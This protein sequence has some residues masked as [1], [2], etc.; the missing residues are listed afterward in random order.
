MTELTPTTR[1]PCRWTWTTSVRSFL[2]A[3]KNASR[4]VEPL[5]RFSITPLGA[6]SYSTNRLAK[7]FTAYLIESA[8]ADQAL[9]ANESSALVGYYADKSELADPHWQGSGLARLGL[10]QGQKVDPR[11]LEL[12]LSGRHHLTGERIIT[13]QG[14]HGRRHL[15]VGQPTLILPDEPEREWFNHHDAA[16]KCGLT[17]AELVAAAADSGIEARL[18]ED[19]PHFSSSDLSNLMEA[20]AVTEISV[21][22]LRTLNKPMS[23]TEVIAL[24]GFSDNYLRRLCRS[25]ASDG[26]NLNATRVMKG[27]KPEWVIDPSDLADFMAKRQ[28]PSTRACFDVTFTMEKSVSLLGLL[29]TPDVRESVLEAVLAANSTGVDHLNLNASNARKRGSMIHTQGLSVAS[30]VHTTSRADDPFLHVHN[31]VLNSVR[32]ADDQ[33]RAVNAQAL[34][35]QSAVASH[36]ATAQLRHELT[37]RFGVRWVPQPGSNV[38]EIDGVTPA[39]IAAFSKRRAEIESA[40]RELQLLDTAKQ[41]DAAEK[42]SVAT[43]GEKTHQD[44]HV[45]RKRWEQEAE[46][47]GL[48]PE[49]LASLCQQAQTPEPLTSTERAELFE[50]LA[51]PEGATQTSSVFVEA[52]VAAAVLRWVP[53]GQRHAHVMPAS[54]MSDLITDFFDLNEVIPLADPTNAAPTFTT[55]RCV[56]TQAMIERLWD[57]GIG[58]RFPIDPQIVADV[59]NERASLTAEQRNLVQ[60]W[61]GSCDAAQSAVG[62]PGTGKTFTCAA[63]VEVFQRAGYAVY[64]AAIKGEAA[65]LL[66]TEANVSSETVAMRLNQIR[67]GSLK[68]N[69][70]TLVLVDESSTI[71]DDELCELLTA[72]NN[73]GATLRCIGDPAQHS[74]VPAGGMW[75]HLTTRYAAHTPELTTTRRMVNTS[76]IEAAEHARRGEISE[77]LQ[78]LDAA[79]QL[80]VY[81]TDSELHA[82]LLARWRDLRTDNKAAP[83]VV[84]DNHTRAVLNATC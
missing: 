67:N 76:D 29:S 15:R 53:E 64:G 59:L 23:I 34:Y 24:T 10:K 80:T 71:S 36:L 55:R 27:R 48:T 17:E 44:P 70:K 46:T 21:K 73:A 1:Q 37:T 38:F 75:E 72:V 9:I 35:R 6:P 33:D 31:I 8:A 18:F 43:R 74:S 26:P 60:M 79:G 62:R 11:D 51:G 25:N 7:E 13:A 54:E 50:Y 30:F 83:L 16:A 63:A 68:L 42:V 39:Q 47:A 28:A 58:S 32:T 40:L 19:L 45:V 22:Q 41:A 61:C 82:A 49:V 57:S 14:N 84:G 3:F 77:A 4:R 56:E 66:G 2:I 20:P 81:Q 78:V 5:A 69:A 12:L 65:R 52:D